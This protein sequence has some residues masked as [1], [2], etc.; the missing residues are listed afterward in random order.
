MKHI[1]NLKE[2]QKKVDSLKKDGA[3]QLHLVADF[4]KTLTKAFV[5]GKKVLSSYALLREGGYLTPD[6][7]PKAFALFDEYHPYEIDHWLKQEYKN[8]KMEEWWEKHHRLILECGLTKN[9]LL[10][11]INTEKVQLREGYKTFFKIL[12]LSKIPLLIFSAGLGDL[13]NLYLEKENLLTKNVHVVSNFFK[14]DPDGK[15][16]SCAPKLIHVF[17]KNE[18]EI[19]TTNYFKAVK[20]RK[21]V[22]LLGD[23]F[24]DIQMTDGIKHE[25]ILRI[26]FL[27][28]NEAEQLRDYLEKFDVV[29]TGDADL[30]D[31]N[32]LLNI[33]I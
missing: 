23:N 22:L 10:D 25:N 6:Y 30:N 33:I 20:D 27:N 19:K 1:K 12:K 16:V 5:Q 11:I 24:G 32:E 4:D 26:G 28:D 3:S 15:A 29:I 13:I 18:V 8:K 31:V 17:N 2:L 9:D 14:F 21:N 7:A